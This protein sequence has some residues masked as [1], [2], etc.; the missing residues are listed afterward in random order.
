MRLWQN[1]AQAALIAL[2]VWPELGEAIDRLG[3]ALAQPRARMHPGMELRRDAVEIG[4]VIRFDY[5]PRDL[6]AESFGGVWAVDESHV[7]ASRPERGY[8]RL[9][10]WRPGRREGAHMEQAAMDEHGSETV[11]WLGQ[12]S[13]FPDGMPAS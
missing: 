1:E 2:D 7:D 3:E 13:D 9:H 10:M 6:R 5:P 4:D 8:W 12:L 11:V